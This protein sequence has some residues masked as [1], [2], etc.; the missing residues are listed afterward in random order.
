V[1]IKTQRFVLI[2]LPIAAL[3]LCVLSKPAWAQ[4]E[5]WQVGR[6]VGL[7]AGVCIREGPGAAYRAHTQVPE[8]NWAVMVIDGPRVADGAI[9]WDT[10]RR[11]AGDPSGGTGWVRMDQTD[12][13]C[14]PP[15][16]NSAPEPNPLPAPSP[17]I[18]GSILD[19]ISAWWNGLPSAARGVV[20]L[21]GL[22]I[23]LRFLSTVAGWVLGLAAALISAFFVW[24]LMDASRAF[25]QPLW[26]PLAF[27]L[28]G[29]DA[30]DL[31]LL[32]AALPLVS[33]ITSSVRRLM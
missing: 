18:Q 7:R 9:W 21:I 28:L 30:P 10:S 19:Q 20:G 11:A 15:S 31:A 16:P 24:M 6:I 13:N 4:Q 14:F 5:D 1:N 2:L 17:D 25:W 22:V 12:T 8:D 27:S 29:P 33:W 26:S 32:V 3:S 23:G